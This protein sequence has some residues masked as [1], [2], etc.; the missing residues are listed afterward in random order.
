MTDS[1]FNLTTTLLPD[2]AIFVSA[3]ITSPNM[4]CRD[5]LLVPLGGPRRSQCISIASFPKRPSVETQ[6]G[7]ALGRPLTD[8]L[9][10]SM[11]VNPQP[12]PGQDPL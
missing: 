4:N 10:F 11:E 9:S 1:L 12:K 8:L 5:L 7:L 3:F 6:K 2:C